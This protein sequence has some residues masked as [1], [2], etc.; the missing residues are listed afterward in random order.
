MKLLR[1][2]DY[3]RMPWKNGGGETVEIAVFPPGAGLDSFEWRVS[4]ATVAADGMFSTFEGIDRTLSVLR[5]ALR[6][7]IDGGDPV[8][9]G[10]EDEPLSFAAD[11]PVFGGPAGAPVIDLNVM[12]RRGHFD[13]KV[14]RL[15]S[16]PDR[17]IPAFD[18]CTL[19]YCRNGFLAVETTGGKFSVAEG[20]TLSSDGPTPALAIAAHEGDA[21]LIRIAPAR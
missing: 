15:R 18:G 9:L 6:L 17:I 12:T 5:G 1:A 19:L 8:T 3:R 4:T 2:D 16:T 7:A 13:H 10:V 20:E 14:E 21:C 11:L